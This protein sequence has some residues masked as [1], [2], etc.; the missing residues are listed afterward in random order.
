[1]ATP[2]ITTDL[3]IIGAGSGGLSIAAAAS[4]MGARVVLVEGGEMGGD[5]LNVGCVPSKALI[6][7]ANHAHAMTTGAPFGIAPVTPKIDF[8]AVKDHI[9]RVIETIAPMDSQARFEGFGVHVIRA[10]GRFISPTDL[11]AGNAIIRARR[12]VIA[13]GSRPLIPAIPGVETV[14][15]L[16]NETIFALREKPSHLIIIGGGPI[17][18]EMAQ[19]HRR[20]GCMVTVIEGMHALGKDDP[21]LAGVVLTAL[22]AEGVTIL[23]GTSVARLI[24]TPGEVCASL[25]DGTAITGS[26]ILIAA[27]RNVA[28]DALDLAAANVAHT[29]K[30]V[31]VGTDLRSSN[32]RVYAVGDAAGGLQFTHV[33]GYHAGVIIRS[34][35]FG[36]PSRSKTAHIPW[37]TYTD[38]EL[39]QVGLTEEQAKAAH[40]RAVTVARFEFQHNDRAQTMGQPAGLIKVMVLKGRPIGASIAGQQAGELIGLWALAISANLKMS[41]IAGMVAPYPTLGEI[42]KRAAGAYFSPQLFANPLVKRVVRL[43]QRFLP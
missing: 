38:P 21:E 31:T 16:T 3:C 13:T 12:F 30:G 37:V 5:C 20:L 27:G 15:Y 42:S 39:A 32:R 14:P 29:A 25:K 10:N 24:G 11:Q 35:M 23:E 8:A 18:I 33:A 1:M 40:G 2:H 17:G 41:A 22:R 34:A 36:L 43:V 19:A 28:L 7:A 4:Q 9:A 26:H 6:A